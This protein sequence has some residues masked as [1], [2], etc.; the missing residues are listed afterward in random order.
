[1]KIKALLLTALVAG[2]SLNAFATDYTDC[3]DKMAALEANYE[4]NST[5]VTVVTL[6]FTRVT[7][8][9]NFTNIQWD[10]TFPEGIR[11]AADE[12]GEYGYVLDGQ[13]S[14]FGGKKKV[15]VIG[16]K[17]NFLDASKYP[18]YTVVGSNNGDVKQYG[19]TKNPCQIYNINVKADEGIAAGTY[20]LKA[21]NI[22]YTDEANDSYETAAEQVICTFTVAGSAVK[23]LNSTKAVSSVKYV[24]V[25]GAES[26]VP[27]DGV[28]IMVTTYADGTTQTAKVIKY[29]DTLTIPQ[30]WAAQQGG[31]LFFENA[32]PRPT[33]FGSPVNRGTEILKGRESLAPTTFGFPV[34]RWTEIQ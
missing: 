1:M 19:E 24:N 15:D 11:P 2:M 20:D 8:T 28:N 17:H 22:K 23:D 27:F 9:T 21:A 3:G 5:D 30:R 33:P 34:N 4:V 16:F 12:D 31:P 26:N 25:A 7:P 18:T 14:Q 32:S 10:V 29:F 13:L 6:V